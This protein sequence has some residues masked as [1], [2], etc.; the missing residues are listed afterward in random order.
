MEYREHPAPPHLSPW[1]E[2]I[3]T[4]RG[5][6]EGVQ[7]VLPDGRIEIILHRGEPMRQGG[8][9]QPRQMIAGQMD[10]CL[11]LEA[12]GEVDSTGIRL[13]PEGAKTFFSI[14]AG[15]LTNRFADLAAVGGEAFA[16]RLGEADGEPEIWDLLTKRIADADR[17]EMLAAV[18]VRKLAA[19]RGALTVDRLAQDMG[20]STRHLNRVFNDHVG[21]PPK[22]FGQILRFQRVLSAW[23]TCNWPR[24][25]DLAAECGFYDQAHLCHEFHRFSG[26]NPS[27]FFDRPEVMALLFARGRR[28]S[29][30]YKPSR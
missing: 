9:R 30:L 13:R 25:A 2:C 24:L 16:R 22:L 8:E 21:I 18:A 17:P 26:T 23:D 20:A 10:G 29:D 3:W 19:S 5:I 12:G 28:L 14:P 1:V 15:L 27:A 7:R 11:L 4:L 6:P